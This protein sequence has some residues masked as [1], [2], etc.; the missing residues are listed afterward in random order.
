MPLSCSSGEYSLSEPVITRLSPLSAVGDTSQ[1]VLEISCQSAVI[2]I[3]ILL[4]GHWPL[5]ARSRV[6]MWRGSIRFGLSD[7]SLS[8]DGAL[9]GSHAAVDG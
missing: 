8:S 7:P 3:S 4:T 1:R 9:V 6:E 2:E 5:S